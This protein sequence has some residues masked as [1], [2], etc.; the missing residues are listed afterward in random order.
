MRAVT[1]MATA[2]F[3]VLLSMAA[4]AEYQVH[5]RVN[6]LA[7][8][9]APAEMEPPGP[10]FWMFEGVALRGKF[11]YYGDAATAG[12]GSGIFNFGQRPFKGNPMGYEPYDH[13]YNPA[14][15]ENGTYSAGDDSITPANLETAIYRKAYD[16]GKFYF[17][18]TMARTPYAD[19]IGVIPRSGEQYNF[20]PGHVGISWI[21]GYLSHIGKTDDSVREQW[22]ASYNVTTGD[23]VQVWLDIDGSRMLVKKLGT[24]AASH[25]DPVIEPVDNR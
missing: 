23:T 16:S 5:Y 17:E 13:S 1:A 25:I 15:W 7:V 18:V 20:F 4:A 10:G 24:D 8:A 12:V 22:S 14:L 3:G 19:S 2:L 11:P 21:G 9:E 6:G